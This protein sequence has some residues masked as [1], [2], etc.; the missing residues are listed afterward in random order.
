M[1][2]RFLVGLVDGVYE[3]PN[4]VPCMVQMESDGLADIKKHKERTF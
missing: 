4:H 3:A 2:S 1:V